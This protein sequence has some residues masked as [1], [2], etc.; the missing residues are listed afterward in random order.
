VRELSSEGYCEKVGGKITLAPSA[1]GSLLKELSE[2]YDIATLLRGANEE[3]LL[4][5]T[6]PMTAAEIQASTG[7]AQ[8]TVYQGLRRLAAIGAVRKIG[9]AY[10]LIE[11]RQLE[12]F[13]DL[14]R[15]ERKAVGIEPHATLIRS[16]G[17]KLKKVL[18][19][20]GARGTLTAF[21]LFPKFGFDYTSPHDFYIDPPRKISIEDVLIHALACS[22]TKA[23]KTICALFYLKNFKRIDPAKVKREAKEFGVLPLWLDLQNYARGRPIINVESFMPWDEF[24]EKA[25]VYG[26]KVSL[27]PPAEQSIAA[28]HEVGKKLSS[29]THAYLFGG[30]NLL[31]RGLKGATKDLDVVVEDE[32]S[33]SRLRNALVASGYTELSPEEMLPSDKRLNPSSIFIAEGMPRIDIF[34]RVI[35]KALVLTEGMKKRSKAMAF[36]RLVIHLLSLEDVFMLKSITEREGDIEDMVAILRRGEDLDWGTFMKTYLEEERITKTHFCF[37]MLDNIEIIQRREAIV[38]PF[39]KELARHCLDTGI[40]LALARGAKTIAEIR[41]LVDFPEYHIRNRVRKLAQEGKLSK[42]VKGKQILLTLTER[43]RASAFI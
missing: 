32:G 8:S 3:L 42:H 33:F 24:L 35:C 14:V 30:G 31:L 21:S 1:K 38:V 12:A 11:D 23:D 13:I 40:L 6:R 22:E 36:G 29:N 10:T 39:Y 9:D 27:P 15:R 26:V 16:D 5:L 7:L 41:E 19:G 28:L 37:I 17:Y 43:G 25:S 2:K 18:A 4:A 34:T 20:R